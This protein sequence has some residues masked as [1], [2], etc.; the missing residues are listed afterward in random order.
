MR[1]RPAIFTLRDAREERLRAGHPW[2]ARMDAADAERDRIARILAAHPEIGELCRS[3]RRVF[4]VYPV[5]GA[6]RESTDPAA[7]VEA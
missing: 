4:Y 6:Y 5:G 3:G 2:L 7:L 1:K